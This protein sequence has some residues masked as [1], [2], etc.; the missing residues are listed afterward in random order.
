MNP[1]PS[2]PSTLLGDALLDA[3]RQAVREE[4][5]AAQNGHPTAELLT[6][7]ELADKLKLPKSWVYEQSR[8]GRIPTYRLG[9]YVR[10]NLQEVIASQKKK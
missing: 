1:S 2:N 5:R 9:K 8:Q 10:F 7:E 4:I 3:I 6:P